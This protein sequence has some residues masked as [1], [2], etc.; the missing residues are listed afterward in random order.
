MGIYENPNTWGSSTWILLNCIS[1]TFP[2]NPTTLDKKNYYRFLSSLQ[3]VLPCSICRQS[4]KKWFKE[5]PPILEDRKQFIN[6]V[7]DTH[8]Y[9]N[10]RLGKPVLKRRE[11]HREI[12]KHCTIVTKT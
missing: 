8:N 3:N 12:M 7:I 10:K 1:M 5:N 9:V 2:K 4:Y 6:W 11:A